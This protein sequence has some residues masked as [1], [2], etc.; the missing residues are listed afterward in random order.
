[1]S[2]LPRTRIRWARSPAA[3]RSAVRA[4]TRTGRTT[5]RVTINA[6]S[7]TRKTSLEPGQQH[8]ALHDLDRV[9]FG[10]EREPVVELEQAGP[11]RHRF[12][13]DQAGDRS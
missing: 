9:L 6:I 3:S 8:G 1:M 7:A 2:S 10:R 4:A 11:G 13:D 12:A 5:C